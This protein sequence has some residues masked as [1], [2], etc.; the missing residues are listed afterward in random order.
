MALK[1][2]KNNLKKTNKVITCMM[3]RNYLKTVINYTE[4]VIYC[5]DMLYVRNTNGFV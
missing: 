1:K 4:H 2:K 3:D 5:Y